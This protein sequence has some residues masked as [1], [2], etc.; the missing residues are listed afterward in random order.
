M[1]WGGS[2]LTAATANEGYAA[3]MTVSQGYIAVTIARGAHERAQRKYAH[4]CLQGG[5]NDIFIHNS[6]PLGGHQGHHTNKKWYRLEERWR[7]QCI[8]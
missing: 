2:A 3:A 7:G 1:M 5:S 8:T 4:A 6:A